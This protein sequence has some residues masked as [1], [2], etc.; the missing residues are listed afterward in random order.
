MDS[1]PDV[2][3]FD[4]IETL[5]S[6]ESLKPRLRKVGLPAES[7][8]LFFGRL[9]RDA[10]AS[11]V[12]G[13]YI[14]FRDIARAT[15]Q[16]TAADHGAAVSESGAEDMLAGFAELQPH[17]DVKAAFERTHLA[18]VRILALTNGS[19]ANTEKLIQRAGLSS[20]VE[21]TISIDAVRHW[22]PHREVYLHAVREAGVDPSRAAMI[23]AHA[24]DTHGAR[25]AGLKTGWVQRSEKQYSSALLLP[26][27]QGT[28]LV[29]VV[30]KLLE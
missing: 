14:A 23:A 5:F 17:A 21:K 30:E 3:I 28:S 19:A 18:E 15:L 9:L 13:T 16:V 29:E 24:W 20:F 2:I 6:L 1:K 11:E 8:P 27:A 7:L 4:V 22:K 26:D 10:F 12:A 25:M